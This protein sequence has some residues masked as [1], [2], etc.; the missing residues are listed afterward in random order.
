MSR[1]NNLNDLCDLKDKILNAMLKLYGSFNIPY[2]KIDYIFSMIRDLFDFEHQVIKNKLLCTS[3]NESSVKIASDV[4]NILNSVDNT[5][6][7]CNTEY[8]RLQSLEQ[9][10]F[11]IPPIEFI[12]G[13]KCTTLKRDCEGNPIS[14]S[15]NATAILFPLRLM[16]TKVFELP[17]V[18]DT[19]KLYKE[20]LEQNV[21]IISNFIQSP[22]WKKKIENCRTKNDIFPLFLFSDDYETGNCLGSHAGSNKLCGTYVSIP[23]LP[24]H[25]QSLNSIFHALIYYSKDRKEFGNFAVFRTLIKELDDLEHIG[26]DIII[27]DG[28]KKTLYF[29]LGLILGD[30]L[31][32]HSI[33][34]FVESFKSMYCCRFCKMDV[35][36]RSLATLEDKRLLRT[37]RSYENDVKLKN[38]SLTGV[39]D[40]CIFNQ[41]SDFHVLDNSAVDIMHDFIEGVMQRD[42]FDIL[43]YYINKAK[44]FSLFDLSCRMKLHDYGEFDIQNKPPEILPNH[45]KNGSLKMSAGEMM[46]FFRHFGIMMSDLIPS[47]DIAY[48][49]YLNLLQI[50]DIILA[51]SI[52]R[53]CRG[54]LRTL[55]SEHHILVRTVF[56]RK[57]KT[58]EH[59]LVHYDTVLHNS[60]PLINFSGMRWESKHKESRLIAAVSNS[61]V[62]VC[63]TLGVKHQLKFSYLIQSN[64]MFPAPLTNSVT[65]RKTMKKL[66]T[67][68]NDSDHV[69]HNFSFRTLNTYDWIE[70][71]GIKYKLRMVLCTSHEDFKLN[72]GI[73]KYIVIEQKEIYFVYEK[74]ITIF[75]THCHAFKILRTE[76]KDYILRYKDLI[77]LY[78]VSLIQKNE[79]NF[80]ILQ[81]YLA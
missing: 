58:K 41:L 70:E 9:R 14:K 23:C 22:I 49:V 2:N 47:D 66:F 27:S 5:L 16:L 4:V 13:T 63:H 7:Q 18:Y 37:K 73:I 69:V 79:D 45:L 77:D 50:F 55:V 40:E 74:L 8:N 52:Q 33:L 67:V 39:K 11:Y 26:I 53:N 42:M 60:G 24:P 64:T 32:L 1:N 25:L 36:Q 19:V 30:N 28:E 31:G 72:F 46:T 54:L 35:V 61:K 56:N 17:G 71:K 6:K 78:P 20:E 48:R 38:P 15:K 3:K 76:C 62:N 68:V 29:K 59:N 75:D 12:V 81:H 51:R 34:G 10:G 65:I 44:L 21:H 80:Y 43:D 57:C